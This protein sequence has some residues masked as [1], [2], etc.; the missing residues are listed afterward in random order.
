MLSLLSV[1]NTVYIFLYNRCRKRPMLSIVNSFVNDK[2]R[3]DQSVYD[4]VRRKYRQIHLYKA[5]AR[6]L[7]LTNHS[8]LV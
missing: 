7:F 8:F 1:D 3:N 5:S 6:H 2:L 4:F